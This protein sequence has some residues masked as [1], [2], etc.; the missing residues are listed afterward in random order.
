MRSLAVRKA[1]KVFWGWSRTAGALRLNRQYTAMKGIQD[2]Y[3]E[4]KI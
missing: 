3:G 1:S 2:F 4:G